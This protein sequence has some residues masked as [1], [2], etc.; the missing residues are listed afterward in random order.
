VLA[1]TG[2]RRRDT[3]G[4]GHFKKAARTASREPASAK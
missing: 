3:A 2:K 4:R 1:D